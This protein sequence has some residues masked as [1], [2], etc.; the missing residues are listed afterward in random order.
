M[1]WSSWTR[2]NARGRGRLA[3][4]MNAFPKVSVTLSAPRVGCP[5]FTA[6]RNYKHART[7]TRLTLHLGTRTLLIRLPRKACFFSGE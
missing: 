5:P 4:G 7:F 3:A 2:T 1:K 6:T